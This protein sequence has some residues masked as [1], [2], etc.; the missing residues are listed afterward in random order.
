MYEVVGPDDSG[1]GDCSSA[2]KTAALTITGTDD[3]PTRTMADTAGAMNEGD[4]SAT[5]TDSGT[6]RD[7]KS[8]VKGKSVDLGGR[9]IIKKKN[10]GTIDPGLA[11]ALV[12][13]FSVDQDR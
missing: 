7:R 13:G 8:V 11:R 1:V 3:Q 2:V 10:D 4:G 6:L 9:R 12:A 5:L